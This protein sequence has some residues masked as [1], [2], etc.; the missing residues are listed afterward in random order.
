MTGDAYRDHVRWVPY[1]TGGAGSLSYAPPPTRCFAGTGGPLHG[2]GAFRSCLVHCRN[3]SPEF[4]KLYEGY[5]E[6]LPEAI[7]PPDF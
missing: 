5:R 4:A 7:L 2:R 6:V 3:Q 1:C